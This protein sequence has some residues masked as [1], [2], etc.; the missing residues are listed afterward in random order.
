MSLPTFAEFEAQARAAGAQEVLQRHWAAGQVLEEHTH[1]FR[2]VDALV[3]EGEMWLSCGGETRHLRPGDR[4]TLP[5]N[6]PHAERYGDA[7]AVYWVG[8]G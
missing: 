8:R 1:P 6:L 3:V 5:A 2:V 4:F 7:G